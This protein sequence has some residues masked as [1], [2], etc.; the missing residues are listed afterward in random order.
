ML[1]ERCDHGPIAASRPLVSSSSES[2][3][4]SDSSH[5]ESSTG[6]PAVY[7]ERRP[8]LELDTAMGRER[9]RGRGM[10]V[11]PRVEC[12]VLARTPPTGSKQHPSSTT[13]RTLTALTVF[14]ALAALA[15]LATWKGGFNPSRRTLAWS[16]SRQGSKRTAL[17]SSESARRRGKG[18]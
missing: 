11:A 18:W 7:S 6:V 8:P 5:L 17:A 15:T 10:R 12:L 14:A 2:C 3:E 9:R 13:K 16:P 4:P 1:Q